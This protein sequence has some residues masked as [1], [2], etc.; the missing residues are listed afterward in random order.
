MECNGCI[1][2]GFIWII[3]ISTHWISLSRAGLSSSN[4]GVEVQRFKLFFRLFGYFSGYMLSMVFIVL[5][6]VSETLEL[7]NVSNNRSS[8]SLAIVHV[9]L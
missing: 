6:M 3:W 1:V 4:I 9:K 5:V 8:Y 7:L 2:Y